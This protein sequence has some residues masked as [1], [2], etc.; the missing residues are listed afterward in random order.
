[1]LEVLRS[2]DPVV[3][4]FAQTV[5]RDAGIGNFV[6]DQHISAVEGSIAAFPR[7]VRVAAEDFA[8]ARRVLSEAGLQA[9]LVA[10]G[11]A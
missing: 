6:A 2:N 5:L 3:I 11:E 7:R 1:M 9:W 4:S 10:D 8:Q